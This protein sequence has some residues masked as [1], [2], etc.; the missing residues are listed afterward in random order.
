MV[1]KLS[2][3]VNKPAFASLFLG[4]AQV[5]AMVSPASAQNSETSTSAAVSTLAQRIDA[6]EEADASVDPSASLTGRKL[7][8]EE[9]LTPDSPD[10]RSVGRVHHLIGQAYFHLG[11]VEQAFSAF[12]SAESSLAEAGEEARADLIKVRSDLAVIYNYK[13]E[14][15][16]ARKNFLDA[17]AFWEEKA[18]GKPHLELAL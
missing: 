15:E 11:D 12:Q 5:G 4:L 16:K 8:L 18:A 7:L 9:A 2:A 1:S 13:G 10:P 17:L 14:H 6:E 3:V